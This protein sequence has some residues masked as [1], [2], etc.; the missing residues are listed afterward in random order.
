[1]SQ[2]DSRSARD[3]TIR[4]RRR[5]AAGLSAPAARAGAPPKGLSVLHRCLTRYWFLVRR[6]AHFLTRQVSILTLEGCG[7][8]RAVLELGVRVFDRRPRYVY[9]HDE[10]RE[11][12]SR[13]L[14]RRH[15]GIPAQREPLPPWILAQN[16]GQLSRAGRGCSAHESAARH[17]PLSRSPR[18]P[19]AWAR[20]S[21]RPRIWRMRARS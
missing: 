9:I 1:M 8:F 13:W 17:A 5:T 4:G 11:K 19:I 7:S 6:R 3:G 15:D 16:L 21:L 18:L 10:W 14:R 2:A 12:H 20:A